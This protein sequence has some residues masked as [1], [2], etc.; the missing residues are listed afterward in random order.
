MDNRT[1]Y[2]SG[3]IAGQPDYRER[4]EAVENELIRMGLVPVNPVSIQDNRHKTYAQILAEDI[5]I[6]SRCYS[7]CLME[8]W[9]DSP[10]AYAEY[11]FAKACGHKRY[12]AYFSGG[13]VYI[14][15]KSKEDS[16]D[17]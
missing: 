16:I 8:G 6:L 14:F 11:M 10:G 4:F 3:P 1:V 5:G 13:E 9:I 15:D 2:I 17:G 7:I 12:S